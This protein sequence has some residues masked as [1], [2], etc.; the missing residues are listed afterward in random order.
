[1]DDMKKSQIR[2]VYWIEHNVDHLRGYEDMASLLEREGNHAVASAIRKGMQLIESANK[3][4]EKALEGLSA[5][6]EEHGHEHPH[7]HDHTHPHGHAHA[8]EHTHEHD[9]SHS[10]DHGHS[11][12]HSHGHD[13]GHSHDHD[14][15]H[16]SHEEGHAHHHPH[17]H[18]A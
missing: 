10:H 11:H 14:H 5:L 4:F 13:H 3:E 7:P 8:H 12:D 18:D 9:H 17:K 1:M 16:H 6:G 15:D 2:L